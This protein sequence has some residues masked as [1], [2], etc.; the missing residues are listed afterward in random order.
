MKCTIPGRLTAF[1]IFAMVCMPQLVQACSVCFGASDSPQTQGVKYS[2]LF[3]LGVIVTVLA[4]FAAFFVQ[5]A[6]RAKLAR[7]S[8]ASGGSQQQRVGAS[9]VSEVQRL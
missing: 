7:V 4:A 9:M 1:L 3:L 6:R 2:V 5:L 8:L